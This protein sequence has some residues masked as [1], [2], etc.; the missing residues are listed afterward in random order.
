MWYLYWEK[1]QPHL[2]SCICC[3]KKL[4][5]DFG[6]IEH[7]TVCCSLQTDDIAPCCSILSLV[8]TSQLIQPSPRLNV[9]PL[10]FQLLWRACSIPIQLYLTGPQ[11]CIFRNERTINY[12]YAIHVHPCTVTVAFLVV[13]V[14]FHWITYFV[15]M[16][17]KLFILPANNSF[18]KYSARL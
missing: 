7:V 4:L 13:I 6:T 3:S 8:H 11:H 10:Q 12:S 18:L 2:R 15:D 9:T 5:T 16:Y 14:N 1:I 17:L